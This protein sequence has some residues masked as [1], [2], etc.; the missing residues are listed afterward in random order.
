MSE[1]NSQHPLLL[2]EAWLP[3]REKAEQLFA[4][5]MMGNGGFFE[6]RGHP[7]LFPWLEAQRELRSGWL[8]DARHPAQPVA[9]FA[10]SPAARL[11]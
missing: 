8:P 4:D 10:R 9:T 5:Y 1:M 6:W 2:P 3:Y 7:E 11:S